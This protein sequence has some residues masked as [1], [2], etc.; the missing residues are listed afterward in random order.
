MLHHASVR[1]WRLEVYLHK[2]LTSALDGREWFTPE[3]KVIW[4][5]G[6][7]DHGAGL[8]SVQKR[9][10]SRPCRELYSQLLGRLTR[11]IKKIKVKLSL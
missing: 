10:I 7:E 3:E 11:R 1:V 9:N 5:G 8:A 4:M 6:C 2:F